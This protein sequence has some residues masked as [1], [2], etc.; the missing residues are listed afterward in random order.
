MYFIF[1]L[2]YCF[3]W[4]QL[5][6]GE[7]CGKVELFFRGIEILNRVFYVLLMVLDNVIIFQ[8]FWLV[9][10]MVCVRLYVC[11]FLKGEYFVKLLGY[12]IYDYGNLVNDLYVVFWC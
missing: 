5:Y 7:V 12:K 8:L 4:L 11:E 1:L 2:I 3:V 9:F 10:C 6:V